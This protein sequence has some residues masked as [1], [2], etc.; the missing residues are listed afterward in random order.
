MSNMPDFDVGD[1]PQMDGGN[2]SGGGNG[3]SGG[4]SDSAGGFPGGGK[5]FAGGF[6]G[7]NMPSGMP[8]QGQSL[9]SSVIKNAVIIFIC[10]ILM[11]VAP[12]VVKGLKR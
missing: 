7:G 11:I 10:L 2:F 6:P 4:D 8:G 9:N 12:A 1:M 5:S 3:F